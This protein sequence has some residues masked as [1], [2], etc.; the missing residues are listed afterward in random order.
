LRTLVVLNDYLALGTI[1]ALNEHDKRVP[2][3]ASVIE[4]DDSPKSAYFITPLTTVRQDYK[5][6]GQQC[7]QY[8]I[9]SINNPGMASCQWVLVPT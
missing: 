1:L 4:F 5:A 8:F 3:E 9:E 7:I 6:L 2:D